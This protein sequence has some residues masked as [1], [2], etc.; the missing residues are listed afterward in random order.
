MEYKGVARGLFIERVNRFIAYVDIDGEVIK[1]HIKNTGRCKELLVRGASVYLEESDNASRKTRY[2]LIAVEKGNIL[3]NMDSQAPNK[4][5]CEGIDKIFKNVTYLKRECKY[6][7]SRFDF[8]MERGEEKAFI[9]VKGVTLEEEGVVRFP[10]APSQRAIKHLEELIKAIENGYKAYVIFVIQL[11]GA[12]YFEPNYITHREFGEK[13]REAKEK[14]VEI[15]A[16]DCNVASN[17]LCINE[18]VECRV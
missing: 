13:L 3:T 4:V 2:S 5:V 17:F 18:R 7:N 6:L 8:Y 16:Y 14:G 1:C 11:R 15:L 10:D 9:E 12:K